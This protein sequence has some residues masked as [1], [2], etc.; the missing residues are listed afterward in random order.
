MAVTSSIAFLEKVMYHTALMVQNSLQ[1]MMN[2]WMHL[3]SFSLF[4]SRL[5]CDSWRDHNIY[6]Y[7]FVMISMYGKSRS[8]TGTTNSTRNR[9]A[10]PFFSKRRCISLVEIPLFPVE[11]VNFTSRHATHVERVML[12]NY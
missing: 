7:I 3:W 8:F 4:C 6:I 9:N 10:L 1:N 12:G 2:E 11:W 5:L